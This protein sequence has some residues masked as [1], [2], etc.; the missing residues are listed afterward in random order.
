M[1]NILIVCA[2]KNLR[3]DVSKVLA[4]ELGF[5]YTDVDEI[6]DYELI[7][8]NLNSLT[9]AGALMHEL[10][11]KS[12]KR[13][14]EFDRCVLTM[15]CNLFVSNANFRV[16]N[17]PKIFIALPKSYFVAKFKA[18]NNRLEQELLLFDKINKLISINCEIVMDKG[19]R[20]IEDICGEILAKLTQ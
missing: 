10:E 11:Q 2:D 17:M 5:L 8:S 4:R 15:S 14:L 13:A 16:F 1:K 9:E 19:T 12:I 3:K 18:D 6:L 7:N 20:A